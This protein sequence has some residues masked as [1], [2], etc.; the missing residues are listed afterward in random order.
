[1]HIRSINERSIKLV[2][3]TPEIKFEMWKEASDLDEISVNVFTGQL[4]ILCSEQ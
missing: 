1:M 3:C 2:A 4:I